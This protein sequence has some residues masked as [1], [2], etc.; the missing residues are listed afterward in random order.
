[1]AARALSTIAGRG[2]ARVGATMCGIAG[3]ISS[4]GAAIAGIAGSVGGGRV[5]ERGAVVR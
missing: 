2:S 1:M 4:V 5:I 3:T